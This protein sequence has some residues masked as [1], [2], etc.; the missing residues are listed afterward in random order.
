M[1]RTVKI[2]IAVAVGVYVAPFVQNA[3][4]VPPADGF[5]AD[6]LVAAGVIVAAILLLDQVF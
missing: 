4:G 2:L 3:I 1:S 5:G 6:D